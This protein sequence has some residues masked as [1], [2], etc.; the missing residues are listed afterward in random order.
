MKRIAFV[1]AVMCA[2]CSGGTG[3]RGEAGPTGARGD[4]GD[5]GAAGA[6][7]TDAG[8]RLLDARTGLWLTANRARIND[9]IRATGRGGAG[10]KGEARPVAT[11]DWDNTV[12]K[13]DMGDATFFYMLKNDKVLQPSGK[14]WSV[15]STHLTAAARTAL[16]AACD[17]GAAAGAP[18]PTST[19]TACADELFS[20]Y[21]AGATKVGAAAWDKTVTKLNNT[22]YA[23]AAQLLEGY[24]PEEAR[25]FARAAYWSNFFAPRG[26]TQTVGTTTGLSAH[27][28]IYEEM[29]D[30]IGALQDSGFDVWITTAS[31]QYVIDA[32]APL[33]GVEPDHVLGI[34]NQVDAAGKLT[35]RLVGCGTV[36]DGLDTLITFDEGKRCWINKAIFREPPAAQMPRNPDPARRPVFSAGDSDTDIAFVKDATVLKLAI[37]RNK[38]QLMCNAYANAGNKWLIQPMFLSP[39]GKKSSPFA[40]TTAT[41]ADGVRITDENGAAFTRDYEDTVYALEQ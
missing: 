41:D 22:G 30:L 38:A 1:M 3:P 5:S 2:A 9:F 19:S 37:N 40:C 25:S 17:A 6:P 20:I 31:P 28:E 11:F 27:V 33:T 10:W 32:I 36:A 24:S 29:T 23:W 12:L 8:V 14:D 4:K 7:G 26:A 18:L 35:A 39:K 21:D 34:R 15:T 16:N 13:N